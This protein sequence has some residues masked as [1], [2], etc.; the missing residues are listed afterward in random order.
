MGPG[1]CKNPHSDELEEVERAE[2]CRRLFE[3][4][5]S[6]RPHRETPRNLRMQ[7][8]RLQRQVRELRSCS[9]QA[10]TN[11][12]KNELAETKGELG[13]LD[14]QFKVAIQQRQDSDEEVARLKKEVAKELTTPGQIIIALEKELEEVK[15]QGEK[16]AEQVKLL[17]T[18]NHQ[19]LKS[20]NAELKHQVKLLIAMTGSSRRV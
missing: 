3:S 10:D 20:L 2:N 16:K 17:H 15:K 12:L 1:L 6:R 9:L 7:V 4:R 13:R 11:R 5:R 8:G 19:K 14:A 18:D